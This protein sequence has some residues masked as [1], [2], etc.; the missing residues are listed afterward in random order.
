MVSDMGLRLF[1]VAKDHTGS[2]LVEFA[3][4]MPILMFIMLGIAQFG[5]LFYNY[6][7]VGYAAASGA[8]LLS[9]SRL[10]PAASCDTVNAIN[11]ASGGLGGATS[12]ASNLTITLSVDGTAC[13]SSGSYSGSACTTALQSAYTAAAIPPQPVSVTVQYTCNANAIL[14]INWINMTGVCPLTSTIQ[15]AV[16]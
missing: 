3:F 16:Q 4:V 5:L 8:R 10:D 7:L 15:Q 2:A 12:C 9:I 1:D 13:A 11:Q 6:H 14:P